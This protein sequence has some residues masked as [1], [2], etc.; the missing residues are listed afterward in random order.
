MAAKEDDIP[1]EQKT[2]ELEHPQ[3]LAETISDSTREGTIY[4]S[5]N[6]GS[7]L[8]SFYV[9]A[10]TR[11]IENRN[12]NMNHTQNSETHSSCLTKTEMV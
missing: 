3:S 6:F 9:V 2:I 4:I 7:F 5:C 8:G 12:V 10:T 11:N 1:N